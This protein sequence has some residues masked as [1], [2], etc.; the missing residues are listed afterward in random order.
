[1]LKEHS[2]KE[3]PGYNWPRKRLLRNRLQSVTRDKQVHRW[4]RNRFAGL[5]WPVAQAYEEVPLRQMNNGMGWADVVLFL[6]RI[7][8][9]EPF[10]VDTGSC[11]GM[12]PSCSGV[13][14]SCSGVP[15]S[16]SGVSSSCSEVPSLCSG[17]PSC[18]RVFS[19]CAVV[20]SN[21]TDISWDC[22]VISCGCTAVSCG[23]TAGTLS[24]SA[25][26]AG[27]VMRESS[28]SWLLL[29]S[30]TLLLSKSEL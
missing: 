17:V 23:G 6:Q 7:V 8:G 19:V 10:Y 2:L 30:E 1:M 25:G 5:V 21:C 28:E 16:C 29:E 11:S 15:S 4:T 14:S 27:Q 24:C 13:F 12:S 18:S 20:S 9:I 22:T 26:P 3:I